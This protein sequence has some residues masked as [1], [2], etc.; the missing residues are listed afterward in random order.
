LII[1]YAGFGAGIKVYSLDAYDAALSMAGAV[2]G[3]GIAATIGRYGG[4]ASEGTQL[5]RQ[6]GREGEAISG[7]AGPKL[8][9]PSATESAAYRVPDKLTSDTLLEA[10]NVAKLPWTK[11]L[12][13]F[14]QYSTDTGRKFVI[15]VRENTAVGKT[16]QKMI[17]Q[18]GVI[19]NKIYPPRP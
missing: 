14:A 18:F 17:D 16:A 10:K 11:Q 9:I 15:D 7:I 2:P 3:L 4:K 1:G 12:Q 8:R 6:L 13:D 5:A 19:I